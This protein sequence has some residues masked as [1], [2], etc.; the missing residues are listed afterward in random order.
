M[1]E[2]PTKFPKKVGG[3][4]SGSQFLECFTGKEEGG[5]FYIKNILKSEIFNSK[6]VFL[7][8]N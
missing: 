1:V 6:N 8:H 5:S 2:P 3:D 7:R 4:L